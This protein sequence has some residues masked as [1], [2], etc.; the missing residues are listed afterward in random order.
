MKLSDLHIRHHDDGTYTAVWG[1]FL[2]KS[3]F[4]PIFRMTSGPARI[5]AFEALCR[6]FRNGVASSPGK[7]FPLVPKDES[8][9][10]ELQTRAVHVLNA[11]AVLTEREWLFLNFDP[12]MFTSRGSIED[13]L[14]ILNETLAIAGI[15]RKRIV[16]EVTE[17]RTDEEHL[18]NL[19]S[20]MRNRG[21]RVA[22]DDYGADESDMARVRKLSPDII[23][24]DAYWITRLMDSGTAGADLLKEMVTS[25]RDRGITTLFEGIEE[26]W[27][28]D[29]A[30]SCQVDFV[31]GYV[32]ARP[33]TVPTSFHDFRAR[34]PGEAAEPAATQSSPVSAPAATPVRGSLDVWDK[35][36]SALM[37]ETVAPLAKAR[38]EMLAPSLV[39][40][41]SQLAAPYG[42]P[43]R[44]GFG[45]K[46]A[47][48]FGKRT[49]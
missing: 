25:F 19:V 38:S 20:A 22:V 48:A 47:V 39:P 42:L 27:Q 2:L 1:P 21:F 24:F 37:E 26:G 13:A 14:A 3:G 36:F 32:L 35:Q 30:V 18:L 40:E 31:Q 4:Q 49:R 17:H 41:A 6:P 34:L 9:L 28:L 5:G 33:Q 11:P 29:L 10:V 46:P 23:K 12:S 16:C 43:A 8:Y 7:F 45:H 15:D 44:P